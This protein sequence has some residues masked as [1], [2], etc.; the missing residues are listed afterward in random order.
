MA[1]EVEQWITVHGVHVPIFKGSS[2]EEAISNFLSKE[3]SKGPAQKIKKLKKTDRF[4]KYI[5]QR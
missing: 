4:R 3:K 1:K 5:K 2:R